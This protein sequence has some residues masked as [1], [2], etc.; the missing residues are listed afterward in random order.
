MY[1]SKR[2]YIFL[3]QT[4]VIVKLVIKLN[5]VYMY[6]VITAAGI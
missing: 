5:I 6:N 3:I 1:I 4:K 2:E